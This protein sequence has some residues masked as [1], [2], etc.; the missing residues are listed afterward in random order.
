MGEQAKL[1]DCANQMSCEF[2]LKSMDE[3]RDLDN[4]FSVHVTIYI[5]SL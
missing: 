1:S 4:N 2:V 3:D 5:T